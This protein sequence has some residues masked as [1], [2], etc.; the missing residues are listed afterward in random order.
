MSKLQ[1]YCVPRGGGVKPHDW[2]ALYM[3]DD[4]DLVIAELLE[5]LKLA[6]AALSGAN[7]DMRVVERKVRAAIAKAEGLE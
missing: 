2:G 3:K 5:A 1:G 6:D 7:M 4:V